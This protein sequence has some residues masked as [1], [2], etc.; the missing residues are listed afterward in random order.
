[1]RSNDCLALL[2][3]LVLAASGVAA[4]G[5]DGAP[6]PGAESS[7]QAASV[8]LVQKILRQTPLVDGHND[9]PWKIR[10]KFQGRLDAIDV[11]DT[12]GLDP[13]LHTDLARLRTGMVGAQFWSVYVPVEKTGGDAV[14]AVLEQID[15]VA[16]LV[17]EHPDRLELATTAADIERIHRAGRVASLVGIEGGHCIGNSLGVLRQLYACGARYMTLAHAKNTSWIDSATDTPR[18]NGLAPFGVE[19]VLE[20]N[21]IGMLVDLSHVSA[22]SMHDVLDVVQAPVIFSHSATRALC[23]YV[24]NVPDDVL[25]RLPA[26]GGI[27]MVCFVPDFVSPEALR[28]R[29]ERESEQA[30]LKSLLPGDSLAVVASMERWKES[31]PAPRAALAQVADHIDHVRD[32]AGIDHVGFGSD[33]DGISTTPVG[34]EDVSR[35]PDLLAEL[36]SRG[37]DAAS[38]RKVAGENAL[39]VLRAAERAATSPQDGGE[40]AAR[41]SRS[42]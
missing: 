20:M 12:R 2:G 14:R 13:P 26:N 7:D 18:Y 11:E 6:A 16:Q 27:V 42:R 28:H 35:F 22:E 21:R 41:R 8:R 29:S 39:R 32:V 38:L 5:G 34:L 3:T 30:R 31:H 36:A 37:Y 19:V 10:D 24:R 40:T 23:D 15:L 4:A 1:M 33:F 25:A 9:L 17:R